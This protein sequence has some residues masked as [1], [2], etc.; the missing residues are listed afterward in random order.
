VRSL[1]LEA[2]PIV[3]T[4]D[5]YYSTTDLQQL[6]NNLFVRIP[7]ACS[8]LREL[9]IQTWQMRLAAAL[10][11]LRVLCLHVISGA[12]LDVSQSLARLSSLR[13]LRLE[14]QSLELRP[15]AALP[16]ALT[17]LDLGCRQPA[18]G[19]V[20]A[21]VAAL[22]HLAHLG[23]KLVCC[24]PAWSSALTGL[25]RMAALQLD[26]CKWSAAVLCGMLCCSSASPG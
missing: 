23:I 21:Q 14:G 4:D 8:G 25:T 7:V 3:E 17:R 6:H 9:R 5:D 10:P 26:Q 13:E 1:R 15:T 18:Q 16:P 19:A 20:P 22:Q 2:S 11:S 12:H 24:D